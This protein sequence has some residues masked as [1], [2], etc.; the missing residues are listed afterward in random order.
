MEKAYFPN[1]LVK[2]ED[3]YLDMK[4]LSL[5]TPFCIERDGHL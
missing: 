2:M 4:L 5:L 3:R 1:L